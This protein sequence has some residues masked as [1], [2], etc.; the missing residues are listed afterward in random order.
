MYRSDT[1]RIKKESKK[2]KLKASSRVKPTNEPKTRNSKEDKKAMGLRK[3]LAESFGGAS[4]NLE[5]SKSHNLPVI[6]SKGMCIPQ[7]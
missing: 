6:K 4:S 2:T 3:I 5:E 1:G 7:F